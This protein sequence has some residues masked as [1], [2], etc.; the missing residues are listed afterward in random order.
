MGDLGPGALWAIYVV[1]VLVIF[2]I[3]AGVFRM[4]LSLSLFLGLVA[5]I[6][7]VAFVPKEIEGMSEIYAFVSLA[8]VSSFLLIASVIWI[9]IEFYQN[10]DLPIV[11]FRYRRLV[12]TVE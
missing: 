8:A 3:L 2:A 6:I 12:T 5:G 11:K 10:P 9:I 1:T 4:I 7:I